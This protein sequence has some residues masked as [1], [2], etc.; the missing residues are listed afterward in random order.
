MKRLTATRY[1]LG[2][3]I[4]GVVFP[5][6]SESFGRKKLYISST[7]LFAA[8]NIVIAAVPSIVAIF[9]GRFMTG[10][11]SSIPSIVVVG[12]IEDLFDAKARVWLISVWL[13]TANTGLVLGPIFAA[14]VTFS[15]GWS[16]KSIC[17]TKP[18][19]S[20]REY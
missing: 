13:I 1:L 16:V 15:I 17:A 4:G 18:E 3:A 12:S 19:V 20:K 10:F 11:L 9:L 8:F 2:Q 7:V 14:Y 6:Y 5:P